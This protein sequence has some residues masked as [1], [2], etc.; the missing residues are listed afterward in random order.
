MRLPLLTILLCYALG[1]RA[2]KVIDITTTDA[3]V[4]GN[5]RI[6]GL[7]G[8]SIF[9]IDKY[10]KIVEG[11]PY[12]WDEWS[13]GTLVLGNGAAYQHIDL[14]LDLLNHEV[15]YKDADQ[16]EMILT[17]PVREIILRPGLDARIFIPGKPWAGVDK[18]LADAW[19]QVLVND[20]VSLLLDIRKT[21]VE[22]TPYA[23]STAEQSIRDKEV[24][25]LLKGGTLL[26]VEKWA[27]LLDLLGDKRKQLAQYIKENDL[28]GEAPLEYA[29]VVAWYN[30]L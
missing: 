20:T 15:H 14:K 17:T 21:L 9:P 27:H 13:T 16:R 29:Q 28:T 10:V 24:Y 4:V 19:L 30:K 18:K 5:E 8:G 2:Q 23:S 22:S 11:S 12:Y 6:R 26:R 3:D 25:F 1:A 7:I